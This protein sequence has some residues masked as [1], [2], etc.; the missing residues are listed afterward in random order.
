MHSRTVSDYRAINV[1]GLYVYVYGI[2]RDK[3]GITI[4]VGLP[5]RTLIIIE[6]YYSAGADPGILEGGGVGV[7]G[8]PFGRSVEI[9]KL[10]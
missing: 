7:S 10:N 8:S 1:Y 3:Y 6:L 4:T 2:I 9:F 5:A